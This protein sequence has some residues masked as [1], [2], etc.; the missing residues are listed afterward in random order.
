MQQPKWLKKLFYW[1]NQPTGWHTSLTVLCLGA[2]AGAFLIQP[3]TDEHL[4]FM[5]VRLPPMCAFRVQT[6]I[7][8]P[9]CGLTRSW[10]FL[11]HGDWT[12]SLARHR[13]GWLFMA[14]AA[15]QGLRHGSWLLFAKARH[16]IDRWGKWL[17]R[18]FFLLCAALF[19]NWFAILW[20]HLIKLFGS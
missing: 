20:P 7:D 5:D 11:A 19:L 14:Y 8:C 15:L 10:V 9:G 13:L 12:T 4:R 2:L 6:G 18:A 17:D 3:G 1:L 16:T